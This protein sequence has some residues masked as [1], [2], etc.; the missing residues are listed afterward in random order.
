MT[1]KKRGIFLTVM[2][3]MLCLALVAGGT[4]A[5]FTDATELKTHLVAG[6][7]EVDLVR[8]KLSATYL[9]A[10]T[11]YL[12]G[13][14]VLHDED[15]SFKNPGTLGILDVPADPSNPNAQP[16]A[17]SV[18]A[19]GCSYTVDMEIRGTADNSVAFGY[20]IQIDYQGTANEF[21]KQIMVS[22]TTEDGTTVT[23]MA[24]D[25]SETLG[26]DDDLLGT[27][28]KNG[29]AKF[30]LTVTFC[31]DSTFA[32]DNST[33]NDSLTNNDAKTQDFEFDI[34]VHAVQATQAP[35]NP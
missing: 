10:T 33:A 16:I 25:L 17:S 26:S 18:M 29:A 27:V 2:T 1:A 30:T 34:I 7:L 9:D 32:G 31:D 4:Y 23:K 8:T 19:P 21:S 5:L 3:L 24:N 28:A 22:V 14:S 20:W 6:T 35:Q 15:I 13:P 11:G 12:T